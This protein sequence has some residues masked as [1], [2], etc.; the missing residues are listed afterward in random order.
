MKDKDKNLLLC[1]PA[2][3]SSALCV[4]IFR[5]QHVDGPF[6]RDST[7]HYQKEQKNVRA[8]AHKENYGIFETALCTAGIE[9]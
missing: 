2:I 9:L 5:A 1:S 3:A 7:E 6:R 8:V 4:D